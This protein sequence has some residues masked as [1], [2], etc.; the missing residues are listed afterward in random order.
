MRRYLI[1][2]LLV[3]LLPLPANAET[4]IA[5][6][7]CTK[8][9]EIKVINALT[10]K[11]KKAS[12]YQFAVTGSKLIWNKGKPT[13]SSAAPSID[14]RKYGDGAE[15]GKDIKP[16]RYW[17]INCVGWQQFNDAGLIAKSTRGAEQSL[18]DLKP[19][20]T[21]LSGC[22]WRI[23]EPPNSTI[24]PTGKLSMKTQLLPGRYRPVNEFCLSGPADPRNPDAVSDAKDVLT[25][26][27][28]P[29]AYELVITGKENWLAYG[30]TSECGGLR[31]LD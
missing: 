1:A 12:E 18:V 8:L 15:V 19:G 16:G 11:C 22:K 6:N 20:E 14:G 30:L 25:W 5:G 28:L 23:G 4:R 13:I 29:K 7:P 26:E 2:L 21:L 10:Y 27:Q 9:G 24:L 31:R 17:T 3:S